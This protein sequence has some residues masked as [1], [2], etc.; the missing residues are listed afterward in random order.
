MKKGLLFLV[1]IVSVLYTSA[2]EIDSLNYHS[3]AISIDSLSIRLNNLQHDY[4]F[5]FCDY[6]LHKIIADL[7]DLAHSINN[8]SNGVVINYYNGRYDR[9]LYTSYVNKYDSDCAL[10]DALKENFESVGAF[11]AVKTVSS[12]FTEKEINVLNASFRV[13]EKAV[14]N[15]ESSLQYYDVAI[16][17]YRN[18]R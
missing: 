7:K 14:I 16:N 18:K 11:V 13:I 5:L 3:A 2:Q 8:S 17:A 1:A 15:V 4:D 12:G 10:F 6:Q 9:A